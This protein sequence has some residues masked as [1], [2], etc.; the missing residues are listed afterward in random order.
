MASDMKYYKLTLAS[1]IALHLIS[2]PESVDLAV[3]SSLN[4]SIFLLFMY[5][6]SSLYVLH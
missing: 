1:S 5:I 6:F 4:D 2:C 3:Q